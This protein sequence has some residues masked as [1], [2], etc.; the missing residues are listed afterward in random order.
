MPSVKAAVAAN[1]KA[2]VTANAK[3]A[4]AAQDFGDVRR[5]MALRAKYRILTDSG[6]VRRK[7][8]IRLLGVRP[9]NRGVFTP[10]VTW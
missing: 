8:P 9:D 5:A 3:A 1:A 4:V 2:A 10:R 7:L 6:K